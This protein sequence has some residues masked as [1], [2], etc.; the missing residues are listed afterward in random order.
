MEI[1]KTLLEEQPLI[2]YC[3]IEQLILLKIRN[4]IDINA[5]LLPWSII[6]L[7]KNLLVVVLKI[8]IFQAKVLWTYLQENELKNYTNQLI[9]NSRKQM[10]THL[11]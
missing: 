5:V 6:F 3:V 2:K 11:L 7:I 8:K 10:Y 4:M 9:K 1:F